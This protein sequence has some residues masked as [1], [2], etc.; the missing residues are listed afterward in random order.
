MRKVHASAVA[1]VLGICTSLASAEPTPPAMTLSQAIAFA[2]AHQPSLAAARARAAVARSAVDIPRAAYY[3]TVTAAA[4]ALVGTANNTTASYATLP[5]LDVTRVGGT[6]ANAAISWSPE[7]STVAGV[8]IHQELY[9]FGRYEDRA[10]ELD[11]VARAAHADVDQQDLDLVLLV[12]DSFYAVQGAKAVLEAAQAAVARSR[13]HADFAHARVTAQLR[14]PIDETRAQADLARY[15]VDEVRAAGALAVAESVLAAAIGAT[16]RA[17]DA[18]TDDVTYTAP[19][20]LDDGVRQLDKIAPELVAARS[21][22]SAQQAHTRAIRAELRPEVIASAELTGRAGGAPVAM[23]STPY[24]DG[25]LPDVPNWNALV[26]VSWPIFDR[27]TQ[28]QARTSQRAEAVRAAELEQA[29]MQLHAAL[30]RAYVELDMAQ[31]A[32]PALQRAVD[33]ATAN[34]TQADARFRAGL[35]DAVE[36]ADSEALLVDSQIQLAVGN[37][38]LSRAHARA[39][40]ALAEVTP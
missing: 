8:A 2:R 31:A 27:V 39:R 28:V 37:F 32:V 11:A 38:Q 20:D 23:Q 34:Q 24:G 19:P 4:E 10:D 26:V 33:A 7:P 5:A 13:E 9:D 1:A 15:E 17:I 40:R 22:L 16:D 36:L 6:P 25:W 35:G 21:L 3:P 12:A 30:D 14:P 29:R 18:S